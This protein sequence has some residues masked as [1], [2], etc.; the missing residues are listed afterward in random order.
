MSTQL[1]IFGQPE[2][3]KMLRDNG[4][5]QAVDHADEV[6]PRWS[7][8][9]YKFAKRYILYYEYF[10]TEDIREMASGIVPDPPSFRAWG[11][12]MVRLAKEGLIR[13]AGFSPVKN[14][15]AHMAFAIRWQSL[16]YKNYSL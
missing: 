11:A 12:I 9:A 14:A 5:K 7:E 1:D 16:I 2:T 3:G 15:K 6:T 8:E 13:K 4:M 10:M